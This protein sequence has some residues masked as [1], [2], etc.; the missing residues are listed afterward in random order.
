MA[1]PYKNYLGSTSLL[2]CRQSGFPFT[3]LINKDEGSEHYSRDVEE[4]TFILPSYLKLV[5]PL[6][7]NKTSTR[8][9]IEVP[10]IAYQ[11]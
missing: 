11:K 8:S 10:N 4:H 5:M 1:S 9:S 6:R 7:V 3:P 2:K